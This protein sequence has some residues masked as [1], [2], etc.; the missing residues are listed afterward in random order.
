VKFLA[1]G[2]GYALFLTA[3]SAVFRLRSVTAGSPPSVV[4][5]KLAGAN[6]NARVSGAD[7]V[8]GKVNYFIGSHPQKWTSG[9]STLGR[10]NYK[11]V[12]KGIDLV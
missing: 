5:M 3:D 12:Y 8:P 10:V 11:E 2:D 1:R 4:R 9:A 7:T 6:S